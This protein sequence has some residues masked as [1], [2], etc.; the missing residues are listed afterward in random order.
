[1]LPRWNNMSRV[2]YIFDNSIK[3]AIDNYGKDITIYYNSTANCSSC[4]YN[5]VTEDATN[6]NCATCN[7]TFYYQVSTA[8]GV[9]AVVK[10]FIGDQGYYD[11]VSKKINFYPQADIRLTCWLSDVLI[12]YHS[13]T[14]KTYF[15]RSD[16][17]YV[18]G[19]YYNVK[20][21][22]RVGVQTPT[23]CIV[24]LEEIKR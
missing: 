2:S 16:H 19:N 18:E 1:M 22:F 17:V 10:N 15:D 14:G 21:I 7:G 4:G 8:Y 20:K 6:P 12:N 13:A 23:V 24:T 9:K 5:P 11:W 3:K